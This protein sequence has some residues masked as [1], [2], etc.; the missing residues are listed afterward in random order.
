MPRSPSR[1]PSSTGD[2]G[3]VSETRQR[4]ATAHLL[5]FRVEVAQQGVIV[6]GGPPRPRGAGA[7][8]RRLL[9]RAAPLAGVA[10]LAFAGGV[11]AATAPGRAECRLV[12]RYVDAWARGDSPQMYSILA[13]TSR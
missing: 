6:V 8:R 11:V 10:A 3:A 2:Y 4:L 13:K 9:T 12:T 5:P 7:R 1:P